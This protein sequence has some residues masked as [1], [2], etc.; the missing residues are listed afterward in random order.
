MRLNPCPGNRERYT[1]SLPILAT[2]DYAYIASAQQP[3][4]RVRSVWRSRH[5][6]ERLATTS[7]VSEAHR[8]GGDVIW[9][10][11]TTD[12]NCMSASGDV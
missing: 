8:G 10:P 6:L 5:R 9:F 11:R 7:G 4:S 12:W 3:T 2:P 1:L